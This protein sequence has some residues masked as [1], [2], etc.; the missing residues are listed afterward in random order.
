M[1]RR[2]L[3]VVLLF[4]FVPCANHAWAQKYR[5][6][7]PVP[8]DAKGLVLSMSGEV[9]T[10]QGLAS[11]LTGRTELLSAALSDLG[12]RT[13]DTE[14]HIALSADVLFDFDKADLKKEATASLEKV[15]TVL[16]SYPLSEV[17]IEGHT[18]AKGLEPYNQKLSERRAISVRQ[19]LAVKGGLGDMHFLTSG[20]GAKK[21]VALNVKPDGSDNPEGRQRNR[22]VE[23]VVKK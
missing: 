18:D 10:I 9:R 4:V 5:I 6:D 17:T 8:P 14:I 12:A 19:W 7:D 3:G 23:I 21:P 15:V 1:T 20:Y 11:Q 13:T 22:R 16:K 2:V